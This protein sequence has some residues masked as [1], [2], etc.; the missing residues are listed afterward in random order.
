M[1]S[2]LGQSTP[3]NG[4][5]NGFAARALLKLLNHGHAKASGM[6]GYNTSSPRKTEASRN[7]KGCSPS[8]RIFATPSTTRVT[9]AH[10]VNHA[11]QA[12]WR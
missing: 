3:L 8:G 12:R 4:R 7:L 9:A 1:Q 6:R 10:S 11:G 2:E 5:G